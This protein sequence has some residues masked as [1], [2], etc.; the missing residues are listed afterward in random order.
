[1]TAMTV[2]MHTENLFKVLDG[3][4]LMRVLP[5]DQ[6]YQLEQAG[7]IA[8]E[9][10]DERIAGWVEDGWTQQRIADEIGITQRGIGKRLERLG[11]R[12][13]SNRGRPKKL[14]Q[15]SNSPDPDPSDLGEE[16]DAEVVEDDAPHPRRGGTKIVAGVKFP[17]D[18]ISET[19]NPTQYSTADLKRV[20]NEL[21]KRATLKEALALY[22]LFITYADKAKGKAHE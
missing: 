17:S 15:S 4:D 9:I 20:A 16:V 18:G 19:R 14:E 11:L 13:Q 1:M 2:E 8:R 6:L 3:A 21:L 7:E 5:S 22:R 12:T 10:L